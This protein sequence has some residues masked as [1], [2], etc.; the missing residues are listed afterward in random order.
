MNELDIISKYWF[1]NPDPKLQNNLMAFGFECGKG[2]YSLIDELCGKIERLIDEK[3][4]SF[5]TDEDFRFEVLQVKE[6]YATLRFY[7]STAPEE[8][9]DLIDEYERMSANICEN[10]GTSPAKII[11]KNGWYVTRCENCVKKLEKI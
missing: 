8:I 4:P 10:C 1:F 5:K 2:W 7:V 3:Y 6:K 9:F 11:N